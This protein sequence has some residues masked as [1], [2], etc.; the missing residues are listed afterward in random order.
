MNDRLAA[1][2]TLA[3]GTPVEGGFFAGYIATPEGRF[4]IAVAPKAAG[5]IKG[6]WLPR[7]KAVPGARSTYDCRANTL[8]MAEAG[9]PIAK[10]ILGLDINGCTDWA[11]PSRDVLEL[12]YRNLK[13]TTRQN[14]CSFRDGD[15]ASSI[16]I[17][18]PYTKESPVQ[19]LAE[20]FR[21]GGAEAFDPAWY[22]A[23]TQYGDSSAC[24]QDFVDGGQGFNVQ[25]DTFLVRAVRRFKA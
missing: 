19:T 4:G 23:S 16:P 1:L 10:Q 14:I 8:A 7:Y 12:L 22:W 17:G 15:N 21:E 5:E 3:Y 11:V 9:S 18:Y 13:P 25:R 24:L 6:Q 2:T 20:A